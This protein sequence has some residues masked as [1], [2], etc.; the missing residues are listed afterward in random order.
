MFNAGDMV[1]VPEAG[2][3]G[4]ILYAASGPRFGHYS[5]GLTTSVAVFAIEDPETG[6]VRFFRASKV[7]ADVSE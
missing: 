7:V 2:V 1:V 6:E 3:S 4:R 5:D